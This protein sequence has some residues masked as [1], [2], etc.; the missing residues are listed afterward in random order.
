MEKHRLGVAGPIEHG[1]VIRPRKSGS[2]LDQWYE[3]HASLPPAGQMRARKVRSGKQR[4]EDG[5]DGSTA[6]GGTGGCLMVS[7]FRRAMD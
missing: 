2:L 5:V 6:V 7:H 4:A 1:C 3:H